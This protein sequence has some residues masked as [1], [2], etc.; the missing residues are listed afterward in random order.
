MPHRTYHITFP[1]KPSFTQALAIEA[2]VRKPEFQPTLAKLKP[3]LVSKL[4]AV[5]P[6]DPQQF[7]KA[8]FDSLP[9]DLWAK[10]APHLG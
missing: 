10:L 6:F 2:G 7:T 5:T 4:H 9:D 1:F 3:A 8:D